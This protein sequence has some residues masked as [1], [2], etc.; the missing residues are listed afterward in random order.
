[1][2]SR[3]ADR[4]IAD[5]SRADPER[6]RDA[7]IALAEL[8]LDARGGAPIAARRSA[9]AGMDEDTLAVRAVEVIA[10]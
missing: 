8:E 6:L 1:M 10:G 2:P 9:T 5:V 3:A 7:L 4:L